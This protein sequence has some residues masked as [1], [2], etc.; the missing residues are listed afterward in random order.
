MTDENS[1]KSSPKSDKASEI[2]ANSDSNKPSDNESSKVAVG[3]T[4]EEASGQDERASAPEPES[5]APAT[6]S[7]REPFP[8]ARLFLTIVFG[9]IAS[10]AFWLIVV[11]AVLQ[12]VTIAIAGQ[13]SEELQ[14]FSRLM[15]RYIQ[16][17][18]DYMTLT[19][20]VQPFPLGSFPKE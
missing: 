19:S 15:G 7:L 20:D 14:H 13:K 4:V 1:N 3:V 12:F 17:V 16:E 18:F 9:A 11:L 8:F 6:P 5:A 2:E 10:F